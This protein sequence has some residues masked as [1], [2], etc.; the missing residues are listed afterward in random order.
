MN[1]SLYVEITLE[2]EERQR[3]KE[4]DK[5]TVKLIKKPSEGSK[6][7][8][9]RASGYLFERRVLNLDI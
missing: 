9:N 4:Q 6:L 1:N 3:E 8:A 5:N 2:S 7:R